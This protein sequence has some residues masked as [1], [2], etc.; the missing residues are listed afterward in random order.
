MTKTESGGASTTQGQGNF[1]AVGT[2]TSLNITGNYDIKT[3][4][5]ELAGGTINAVPGQ[6]NIVTDPGGLIITDLNDT[7]NY[8]TNTLGGNF[9]VGTSGVSGSPNIGGKTLNDSGTTKGGV[10][11]TVNG[12][13]QTNSA[14]SSPPLKLDRYLITG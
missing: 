11:A 13:D 5:A 4:T 1:Q 8:T 10:T 14:V 2:Q 9:S 3:H 7:S 6:G 12:V